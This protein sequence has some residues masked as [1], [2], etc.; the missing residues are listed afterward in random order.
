VEDEIVNQVPAI[1]LARGGSKGVPGKNKRVIA[2]LPCW[3]WSALDAFNA[4]CRV[5]VSSDDQDIIETAVTARPL[6]VNGPTFAERTGI[7]PCEVVLRPA[8]LAN[9]TATVQ[10]AVRHACHAK[11]IDHGPVVVLYGCVPVRP[12]WLI[13]SALAV[14][15]STGA[16]SV[17]SYCPAGK[18]H[19]WWQTTIP[20]SGLV[21]TMEIAEAD[22]VTGEKR[23]FPIPHRRQDL[24][25]VHFPDGGVIVVR[26]V[27]KFFGES[28]QSVITN[29][30][31]VI[32]IDTERDAMLADV[33]LE[34][35]N[36]VAQLDAYVGAIRALDGVKA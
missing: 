34:Q 7:D 30:G 3:M 4:G 36:G 9:D 18:Y 22:P 17:Q 20:A 10:D 1:I 35:R 12:K 31:D 33:V 23:K 21:P 2:G 13:S 8:E 25:P 5:I 28:R 16:D 19:P 27:D 11:G 6:K 26:D 24:P 15:E 32:D 29:P 14:L